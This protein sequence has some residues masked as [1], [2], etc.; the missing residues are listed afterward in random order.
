MQIFYFCQ[1]ILIAMCSIKTGDAGFFINFLNKNLNL[2]MNNV[3]SG[4]IKLNV[5]DG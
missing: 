4:K 3:I 5:N 2:E 1:L